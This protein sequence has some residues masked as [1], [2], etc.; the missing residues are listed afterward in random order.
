MIRFGKWEEAMLFKPANPGET[1]KRLFPVPA[2]VRNNNPN[3]DQNTGY[4]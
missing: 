1:Y 3:L 2:S 4:N